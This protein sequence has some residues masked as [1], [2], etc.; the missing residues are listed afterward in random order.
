[1]LNPCNGYCSNLV[2]ERFVLLGWGRCELLFGRVRRW[3]RFLA[4]AA[5]GFLGAGFSVR[6]ASFFFM[7]GSF[8]GL[9]F[10]SSFKLD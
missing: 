3:L 5:A 7:Y 2:G 6:F 9:V 10:F 4:G 1:M 8:V